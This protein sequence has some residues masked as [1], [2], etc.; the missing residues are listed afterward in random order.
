[1]HYRRL[2]FRIGAL[3]I[4]G[5]LFAWLS[6]EESSTFGV[7]LISAGICTWALLNFSSRQFEQCRLTNIRSALI[8]LISG[9]VISPLAIFLMAFKSG[10][11]GHGTPDFTT[12]QIEQVLSLFPLF[13]LGGIL[14]GLICRIWLR[15]SKSNPSNG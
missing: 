6:F 2:W 10:L 5:G 4:G 14:S 7:L 1:M 9:L 15:A 8:G 13:G 3:L 11:H 12:T